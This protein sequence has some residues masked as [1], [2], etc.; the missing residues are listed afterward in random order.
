MRT[1]VLEPKALNARENGGCIS[2]AKYTKTYTK[3]TGQWWDSWYPASS[4]LYTGYS[5]G[6]GSQAIST[7]KSTT[8][9]TTAAL[10]WKII[11]DVLSANLGIWVA[12]GWSESRTYTCNVQANSVVQV[13]AQQYLAWGWF[14]S[15]Q[16]YSN[17]ACGGCAGEYVNGGATAPASAPNGQKVNYGCSTGYDKVQ[18]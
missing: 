9:T 5:D 4:C 3:Q 6:G 17:S 13:W 14:W 16:C 2:P 12:Q 8:I 11:A 1:V 18:C 7:T 15:Q 10:D